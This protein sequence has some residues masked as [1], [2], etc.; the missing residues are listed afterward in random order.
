MVTPFA[1]D[2]SNITRVKI[3]GGSSEGIEAGTLTLE[4]NA[5]DLG[6]NTAT[7]NAAVDGPD[8]QIIF[9]VKYLA[10][11]LAIMDTPEV[12][13]ELNSPSNPGVVRPVGSADY[14]YVIMPMSTNR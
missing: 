11:V 2:S 3:N 4:S 5:E 8:V 13:L 14:T 7:I 9:N 10:E 12:S 1:R 6:D